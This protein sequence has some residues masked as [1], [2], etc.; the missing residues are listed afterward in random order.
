MAIAKHKVL[1]LSYINGAL[2]RAGELVDYEETQA[3]ENLKKATQAE[4]EAVQFRERMLRG[5]PD[6]TG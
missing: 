6:L 2:V 1:E 5:D 4:I 3:G